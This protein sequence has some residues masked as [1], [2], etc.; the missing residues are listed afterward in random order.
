MDASA[1]PWT[2]TWDGKSW[3]TTGTPAP[4]SADLGFQQLSCTSRSF[5][6]GIG[7]GFGVSLWIWTSKA[8]RGT[9]SAGPSYAEDVS[10]SSNDFCAVALSNGT[11]RTWI[12]TRW[13]TPRPLI[14]AT[15][16]EAEFQI[17]CASRTMCMLV[18]ERSAYLYASDN[19]G[20]GHL[21]QPEI[22]WTRLGHFT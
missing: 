3:S 9:G 10:C 12:G 14:A 19:H 7:G 21:L 17:S 2:I 1:G 16:P 6:A 22:E 5:C 20:L 15:H 18:Y 13:S 8:W 4:K 11:A